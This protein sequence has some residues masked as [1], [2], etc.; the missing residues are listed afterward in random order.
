MAFAFDRD[1]GFGYDKAPN[2]PCKHLD[3]ACRCAVHDNRKSHGM[4][5]CALYECYGAGQYVVQAL[6][7][8]QSWQ[9]DPAHFGPMTE[10]FRELARIHTELA[11]LRQ[12]ERLALPAG[13][14]AELN[15][16]IRQLAPEDGWTLSDLAARP[17]GQLVK[18]SRRF[19]ADLKSHLT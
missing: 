19:L 2:D 8:G 4:T 11:L 7:D 6:F 15:N 12:A 5:A 10:A 18:A 17:A 13:P 9:D 1:Q 14:M 16:L 3:A